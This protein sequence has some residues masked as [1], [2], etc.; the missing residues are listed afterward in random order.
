[1][2]S[3]KARGLCHCDSKLM[4]DGRCKYRCSPYADP[5]WLRLQAAKRAEREAHRRSEERIFI[6]QDDLRRM[7]RAVAKF[8]KVAAHMAKQARMAARVRY[9][10]GNR[11]KAS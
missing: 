8:D 4:G 6:T 11:R 3:R 2:P 9:G 5:D 7:R 10:L 1:M